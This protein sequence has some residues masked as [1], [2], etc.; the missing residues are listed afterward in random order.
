MV[1]HYMWHDCLIEVS[2]FM[3]PMHA[4]NVM[5]LSC[6]IQYLIKYGYEGAKCLLLTILIHLYCL[7]KTQ[8]N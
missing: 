6:Y 3:Q 8:N 5:S 1:L 7:F 2:S 4:G